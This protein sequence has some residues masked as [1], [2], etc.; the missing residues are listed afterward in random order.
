[1][2]PEIAVRPSQDNLDFHTGRGGAGNEHTAHDEK[3]TADKTHHASAPVGLAD[4]LKMKL[5]GAFKSHK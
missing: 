3:K 2:I 5:F 4:R 1:M